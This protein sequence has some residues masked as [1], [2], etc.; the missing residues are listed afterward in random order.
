MLF[1]PEGQGTEVT[2]TGKRF[3]GA[4]PSGIG[5]DGH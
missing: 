4:G 1:H 2:D 3:S 5:A